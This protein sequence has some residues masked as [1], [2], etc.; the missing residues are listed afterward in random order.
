M[1]GAA[2]AVG[3][4]QKSL[5]EDQK[6]AA[7]TLAN[8]RNLDI[9]LPLIQKMNNKDFGPGSPAYASVRR[10]LITAGVIDPNRTDIP[11]REQANKYMLKYAT[12]AQNAGRSDQALGAALNS[13]PNLD[14]TQPSNLHLMKNQI[15]LDKMEAALPGI[16]KVE[17]P[18]QSDE[19]TYNDYK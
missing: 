7:G 5:V 15:G 18:A 6:R 19:A 10:G 3:E 9:A 13:N 12:L 16:F 1:G 17:H 11:D 8:L 4:G 2:G 14:L